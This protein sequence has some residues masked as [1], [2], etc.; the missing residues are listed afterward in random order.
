MQELKKLG[1]GWEA[2]EVYASRKAQLQLAFGASVS[3][4]EAQWECGVGCWETF[5]LLPGI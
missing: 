4:L 2:E 1:R 5:L 3:H